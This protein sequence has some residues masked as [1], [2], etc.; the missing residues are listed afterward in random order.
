VPMAVSGEAQRLRG[1]TTYRLQRGLGRMSLYVVLIVGAVVMLLP[2]FWMLSTSFKT[3][4]D[5]MRIPPIWIP[6]PLQWQNYPAAWHAAPFARYFFNSFFISSMTMVG[7]VITCIFAGY[8]FAKMKFFGKHVLFLLVLATFMIPGHMLLVPSYVLVRGLGWYDT[9]WALIM[10]WITSGFGIFLMRQFFRTLPD[11]LWDAARIDGC[12]RVRYVLQIA[13]PMVRPGIA[14]VA[15]LQFIN[16]WNSF[17]WVLIMT[18]SPLM[19]T[20]PV[21]LRFF[22]M[23][24]GTEYPM[25]MAA[26]TMAIVPVI[27]LFFFAQKHFVRGLARTGVK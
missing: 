19:R 3:L 12:P 22:Q 27:I 6:S 15:L 20:I 10:P 24:A 11:E 8:A 9:Y 21:G 2:F 4:V 23:E 7:E 1:M 25:L 13:V 5:A 14:T 18:D 17:L 16:S 26:S